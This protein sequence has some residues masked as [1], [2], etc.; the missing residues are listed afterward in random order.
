MPIK[1]GVIIMTVVVVELVVTVEVVSSS[2]SRSIFSSGTRRRRRTFMRFGTSISIWTT[3][4]E[5]RL[6]R[7]L[8][9]IVAGVPAAFSLV[10]SLISAQP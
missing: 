4:V 1:Q 2:S 7:R 10:V 9:C 6:G 5:R 8:R 3:P